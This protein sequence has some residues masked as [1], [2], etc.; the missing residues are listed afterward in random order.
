[1]L[2]SLLVLS[3]HGDENGPWKSDCLLTV[4][5]T[6]IATWPLT[7]LRDAHSTQDIHIVPA[8]PSTPM[9]FKA[10][11]CE[12]LGINLEQSRQVHG[13]LFGST[14]PRH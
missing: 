3:G 8:D 2:D 11:T 14:Q 9:A 13:K 6:D 7:K 12:A 1:M 5:D 10:S 4:L